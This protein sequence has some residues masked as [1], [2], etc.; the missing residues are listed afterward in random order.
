MEHGK[1]NKNSEEI[2]LYIQVLKKW[3]RN[4]KAEAEAKKKAKAEAEEKNLR[5]ELNKLSPEQLLMLLS[6]FN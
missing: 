5:N 1:F 4:A 6:K 2:P 3:K